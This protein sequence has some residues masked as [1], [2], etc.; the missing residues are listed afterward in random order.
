MWEAPLLCAVV[1]KVSSITSAQGDWALL[2][3]TQ[4]MNT[5]VHAFTDLVLQ[6]L[7]WALCVSCSL[8][9][10]AYIQRNS[11]FTHV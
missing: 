2:V 10:F 6:V 9:G 7:S 3:C 8:Q 5:C 4:H 1:Y 11:R